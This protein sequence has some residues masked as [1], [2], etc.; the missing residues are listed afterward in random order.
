MDMKKAKIILLVFATI[1]LIIITHI[2]VYLNTPPD[3][4][5]AIKTVFIPHGASFS[6]VADKLEREGI[7]KNAENFTLFAKFNGAIKNVKAGEYELNTSMLPADVLGKITKGVSKD[8]TI[9]I[10]EGYNIYQIA[11]VFDKAKL[12]SRKEFLDIAF[13]RDF[14]ASL[15]IKG[16]SL[17]GFL[18]P[19]TYRFN[20]L[21]GG[22]EIIRTMVKRFNKVYRTYIKEAAEKNNMTR[23]SVVIL[24]SII[25]KEAGSDEEKAVISAVFHNRLKRREKLQSD[26]T[27]IYGIHDFNGNL[28]KKDIL[29]YTPYNTYIIQ[30]LPPGPIASPGE[31]ALI[32]A[33]NPSPVNYLYFVSK[34]DGSHIF[35]KTLAEHNRAVL[36]YQL[37]NK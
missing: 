19:D 21:M 5:R 24:A 2:Y 9:T 31:Q 35:S 36:K 13:D 3:N 37:H 14:I 15:G 23:E 28:K 32:A 20:K 33:V 12:V 27:V 34:N 30:G 4:K 16:R 1:L 18:F 17:E 22:K 6:W 8:Y 25:E 29:T 7:I 26:P 11:Q 10:P